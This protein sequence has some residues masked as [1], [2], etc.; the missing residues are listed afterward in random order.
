MCSAKD[1]LVFTDRPNL[2]VACY[3]I[4][5]DLVHSCGEIGT[6]YIFVQFF[7][8]SYPKVVL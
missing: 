6:V 5:A 3:I 2:R 1:C 8:I 4:G 7:Q